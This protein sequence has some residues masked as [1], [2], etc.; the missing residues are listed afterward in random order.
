[1][2]IMVAIVVIVPAAEVRG[3]RACYPGHPPLPLPLPSVGPPRRGEGEGE[4][5]NVAPLPSRG[6]AGER[7]TLGQKS[8]GACVA[9]YIMC[10]GDCGP[11]TTR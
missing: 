1:M 6:R 4:G 9:W 7:G 2:V 3:K 11:F 10:I 5:E 8:E